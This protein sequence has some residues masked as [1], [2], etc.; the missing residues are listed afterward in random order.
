MSVN[1]ESPGA[2]ILAGSLRKA[3][4][5][6]GMSLR[7]LGKRIGISYSVISYWETAQRVP[8]PEDVAS[9]LTAVGVTGEEKGSI[10]KV[11]RDAEA[12]NYLA[13][14][15]PGI[16]QQLNGV[17]ECE[18]TASAMTE[19]SPQLIPGLLQTSGYARAILG[20]SDEPRAQIEHR[21]TL[22]AGRRDALTLKQP[23][24]LDA[25]IGESA[26]RQR[27]GGTEAMGEQ[28]RHLMRFAELRSVTLRV[29]AEHGDWH[30]GLMGPFVLYEFPTAPAIVHLEHHRSGV[31]VFDSDDV[32]VY[33]IAADT[34]REKAMSPDQSKGLIAEIADEME[35]T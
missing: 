29:I 28:L 16:S 35:T 11:A 25:V 4:E 17:L 18:R 27:I 24:H 30:P 33:K 3:R 14:G 6:T 8:S 31:F 2:R 1:S 10:L 23:L 21:V 7:E 34:L 20:A 13:V 15:V 32:A 19:W 22:R 26:L 5:A 9:F 12:P